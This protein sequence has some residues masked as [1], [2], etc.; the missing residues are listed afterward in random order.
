MNQ[1]LFPPAPEIEKNQVLIY[2]D[3]CHLL[4]ND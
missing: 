3:E 2:G 4:K 1:R